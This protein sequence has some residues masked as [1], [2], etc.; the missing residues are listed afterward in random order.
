[1]AINM[2][3]P[4]VQVEVQDF[5]HYTPEYST[6]QVGLVGGA[7]KGPTGPMLMTSRD[8]VLQTYGYPTTDDYGIISL[9]FCLTRCDQ[10]YYSRVV[11]E[12]SKATA[13]NELLDRLLFRTLQDTSQYNDAKIEVT[14]S[15]FVSEWMTDTLAVDGGPGSEDNIAKY[16]IDLSTVTEADQSNYFDIKLTLLDG[17]IEYFDFCTLDTVVDRVENESKIIEVILNPDESLPIRYASQVTHILEGGAIGGSLG[18][19]ENRDDIMFFTRTY[20][21]TV[22]NWKVY[23]SEKSFLNTLDYQLVDADGQLVE[24]YTNLVLDPTSETYLETFINNNSQYIQCRI[25]E[26]VANFDELYEEVFTF[27]PGNHGMDGIAEDDIIKALDNFSNPETID[28]DLLI[29]PSWSSTSVINKAVN[30]CEHRQD[31]MFIV[32]PPFGLNPQNVVDWCNATGNYNR[33]RYG[34]LNSSFAAVYW[35]W[36]QVYDDWNKRYVWMPPSP[37]VAAQISFS[38]SQSFPWFAPAGINRGMLTNVISV[39]MS[40]SQSERDLLYGNNNVVNPIVNFKNTGIVIWG[41]KTTLRYTNAQHSFSSLN[42]V[43]VRRL[44]NY[45]KRL[46]QR[47]SLRFI[48]DPNDSFLQQKWVSMVNTELT[49]IQSRRGIYEFQVYM[50]VTADDIEN[51]RMPGVVKFKPT[52]AA[53]FIPITFMLMRYTDSL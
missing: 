2:L 35:P 26:E 4:G 33:P 9:L 24:S 47:A 37:V 14:K 42:R 27:E 36:L 15:N 3:S 31:C 40:P 39:E 38:D 16:G 22:K 46:I 12:P 30:I 11:K 28:I 50:N 45:L 34:L 13:G 51:H 48:F 53:E 29:A 7:L 10:V 25:D 17:T 20:D 52:K 18:H 6:A 43:N 5:S 19:T 41:Q 44:T 23:L 1:M 32:D 8:Q 49:T 21:S